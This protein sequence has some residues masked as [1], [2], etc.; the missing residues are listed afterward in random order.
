MKAVRKY[1]IKNVIDWGE[2]TLELPLDAVVLS[3]QFQLTP[4]LWIM[5]DTDMPTESRKFFII[6]TG[7]EIEEGITKFLRFIATIQD[8]PTAWH[9]FERS[10]FQL[11]LYR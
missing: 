3:A 9:L 10:K 6:D 11:N 5:V 2:F 8:G 7:R 4:T 1:Q